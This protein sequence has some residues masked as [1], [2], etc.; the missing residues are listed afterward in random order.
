VNTAKLAV[1][2]VN[3]HF[4]STI[5][6]KVSLKDKLFHKEIQGNLTFGIVAR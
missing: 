2:F 6:F 5:H 3:H 1:A 4:L